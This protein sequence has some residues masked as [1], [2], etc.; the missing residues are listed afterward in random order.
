MPAKQ[1]GQIDGKAGNYR[2]RWRDR[3]GNRHSKSGFLSKTAARTYYQDVVEP[4]LVGRVV[5]PQAVTLTE[6]VTLYL[7]R[8]KAEV[9]PRTISTLRERLRHAESRFGDITLHEFEGMANEVAG[10]ASQQPERVRWH[11][12]KAL[13]QVLA[14]AMRWGYMTRNPAVE[15]GKIRRPPSRA[16][17]AYSFEELEAIA[18]E[19]S[20]MYQPLPMFAAATGLRPE[21]WQA[22]ER[23]DI[24]RQAGVL[25]VRRTVSSGEVTERGKTSRSRRQVPLSPRALKALDDLPPRL[26]TPLLFPSPEGRLLQIDNFRYREWTPAVE[27]AHVEKP[28]RIYDT[29]HTFASNA[30]AAGIGLFELSRVM[31]TSPEEIER[32]Y[33]TLLDGATQSIAGRLATWED[34]QERGDEEAL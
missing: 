24:D 18:A 16:V 26:D 6:F 4:E 30:I 29:R 7:D 32:T 10:W 13:R 25:Y 20:P 12:V 33:A 31:G 27:A 23:K 19:L 15:M 9:R 8:H 5:A 14:A 17:R 2:L 21:E 11:R 3:D 1:Q 28:A 34:Q 22:L